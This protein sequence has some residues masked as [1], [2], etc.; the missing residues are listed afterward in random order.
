MFKKIF[1]FKFFIKF[2][3]NFVPNDHI[4]KKSALVWEAWH[5]TC[6]KSLPVPVLPHLTNEFMHY[7][8]TMS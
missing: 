7:Q 6:D 8:A 3:P 1:F 2:S 5:L 4:D